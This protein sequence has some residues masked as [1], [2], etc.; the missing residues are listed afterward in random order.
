MIDDGIH[1]ALDRYRHGADIADMLH[2]IGARGA[3][4]FTTFDRGLVKRAGANPPL[5]VETL[6]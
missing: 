3:T 5:A 2:L 1:R 4:R 6:R